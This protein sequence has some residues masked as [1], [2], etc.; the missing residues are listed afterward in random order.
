MGKDF[1]TYL[2]VVGLPALALTAAAVWLAQIEMGRATRPRP[3]LSLRIDAKTTREQAEAYKRAVFEKM[4]PVSFWRLSR[5]S[6]N[7]ANATGLGL[8]YPSLTV[9]E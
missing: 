9:D 3:T 5:M 4:F 1:R 2:L 6:S 8:V 7:I